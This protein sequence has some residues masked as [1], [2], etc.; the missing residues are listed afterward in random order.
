MATS[1]SP[2]IADD[3]APLD[4]LV[5]RTLRRY[6]EMSPSTTDAEAMLMFMDYANAIVDDVMEHPYWQKGVGIPYYN[7]TTEKRSVP[8]N[9]MIAGLLAKYAF[10]KSSQKAGKYEQ[11]YYK[12]LNQ[13]L[14]RVK[15][16]VGA[17]FSIQVID[18]SGGTDVIPGVS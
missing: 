9:I 4:A 17:E 2:Q 18:Y 8:D 6:G 1:T 3:F 15:F 10:D 12:R 16:G 11:D 13:V 7:H 5:L 14:A